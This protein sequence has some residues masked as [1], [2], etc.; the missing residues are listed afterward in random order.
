VIKKII[1]INTFMVTI[2]TAD[3][4]DDR[5]YRLCMPILNLFRVC[6][7]FACESIHLVDGIEG[8]KLAGTATITPLPTLIFWKD[9][10]HWDLVHFS[11]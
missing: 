11:D 8:A 1:I 3:R 5:I 2:W 6:S 4:C 7:L 9:S 10:G